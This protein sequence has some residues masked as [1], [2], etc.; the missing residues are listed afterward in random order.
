MKSSLAS[1]QCVF[2][3]LVAVCLCSG[4]SYKSISLWSISERYYKAWRIMTVIHVEIYKAQQRRPCR[5][6]WK[7]WHDS[8]DESHSFSLPVSILYADHPF[9]IQPTLIARSLFSPD[10][11]C[12]AL[13]AAPPPPKPLLCEQSPTRPPLFPLSALI[14][15]HLF[16]LA[17][18]LINRA[19][20]A[21]GSFFCLPLLPTSEPPVPLLTSCPVV[22]EATVNSDSAKPLRCAVISTENNGVIERD[23]H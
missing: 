3:G 10:S 20:S 11:T 18:H 21:A 22:S 16:I 7:H 17:V 14:D 6:H 4:I 23:L 2:A 12:H 5:C 19:P 13:P 8:R 1:L 15:S 9:S